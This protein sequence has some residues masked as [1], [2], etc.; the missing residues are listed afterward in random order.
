ML[1]SSSVM[2]RLR[3]GLLNQLVAVSYTE[4]QPTV[5]CNN[6]SVSLNPDLCVCVCVPVNVL[7]VCIPPPTISYFIVMFF[8]FYVQ[9]FHDPIDRAFICTLCMLL[10]TQS[11]LHIS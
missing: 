3:D 4:S 5:H 2:T 6:Y 7:Q 10:P 11:W 8:F 1:L 9:M